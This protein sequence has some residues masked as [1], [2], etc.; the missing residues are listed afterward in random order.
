M[1]RYERTLNAVTA[2]NS[3]NN[4]ELEDYNLLSS[5]CE[6]FDFIKNE[7]LDDADKR[8]LIYLSNKAGIPH[9]YDILTNFNK[10]N[11]LQIDDENIGLST[12][13]SIL[14]E[15]TLYTDDN[16]KLHQYQKDILD[17]FSSSSRNRYFLSASTSFGK[18]HLV[19]EV[20][21]KIKY[22]NIV[23]IFPSIALLSDFK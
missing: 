19:Y 22:K 1:D 10:H 17:L 9:Y 5:V 21:K 4:G 12:I 15:S 11:S 16:S 13:S 7:E 14:Y 20:I 23:L 3:F 2:L 6:Y 8:F 18:T